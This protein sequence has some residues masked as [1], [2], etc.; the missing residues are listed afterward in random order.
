MEKTYEVEKYNKTVFGNE[1]FFNNYY[2][3]AIIDLNLVKLDSILQNGILC[4]DLI[5]KHKLPAV[6]IHQ[7]NA[8]DSKNGDTYISLSKYNNKHDLNKVF[9]SLALHTLSSVSV[10][11]NKDIKVSDT[12]ERMTFFDDEVFKYRSIAPSKIEGIIYPEHLGNL[13]ISKVCC[14]PRDIECYREE[15]INL[16]ID[17]M[18]K[19][20]NIAMPREEIMTSFYQLKEI[21]DQ[22]SYI[23]H[24]YLVINDQKRK[25]GTDLID[26]LASSLEECWS[27][28]F[29]IEN[30]TFK[31]VI[32]HINDG[33]LPVYEIK[34]KSLKQ[35]N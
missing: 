14:L 11:V 22:Y 24:G 6:Y 34:K 31:D 12:G 28:K 16:W 3:H 7:S 21:M 18:E 27:E 15:Y 4:K 33:N 13:R 5:E 2:F 10:L 30:P 26:V 32:M 9:S 20:F 23:A 1:N 25:Y 19:Y 29:H 35:V 8:D 17:Y